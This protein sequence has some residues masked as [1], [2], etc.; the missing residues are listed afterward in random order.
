[1]EQVALR[2]TPLGQA[3]RLEGWTVAWMTVECGVAILA[4]VSAR[5]LSLLA[6]GVDSAIEL[7]SAAVLIW[8][9]R[10]EL[11]HDCDDAGCRKLEDVERRSSRM[12]GALLLGLALYVAIAALAKLLAREG[13]NFSALG[14]AITILAIPIM[15]SLSAAKR[16]LSESLQSIS[17]RADAAQGTACWYLSV[18]VL[19]GM[20]LQALIG[21]WWA[22]GLASLVIVVFLFREGREAWLGRHCC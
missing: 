5:S 20:T 2:R 15:I 17:L 1:M 16:R 12:A 7:A 10:T 4:A 13:E 21:A 19:L 8:R 9:L 6:F 11:D 18:A 3:L 22:D 14:V